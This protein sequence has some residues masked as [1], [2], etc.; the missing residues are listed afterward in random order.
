MSSFAPRPY[1]PP[2]GP[3]YDPAAPVPPPVVPRLRPD[4]GTEDFDERCTGTESC[5]C[6]ECMAEVDDRETVVLK[7]EDRHDDAAGL[8]QQRYEQAAAPAPRPLSE[9]H[10]DTGPVLWWSFP[11][12]EPPYAGT[13][14][15]SDFPAYVTHF[16]RFA[17]PQP[18][19]DR[20]ENPP[21]PP[22]HRPIA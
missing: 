3:L 13:P 8:D 4:D 15:D 16:T 7:M 19:Y 14:L 9:W 10:E 2:P 6:S 22:L 18:P 11:V 5:E 12:Q 20:P 17:V 21:P 1:E